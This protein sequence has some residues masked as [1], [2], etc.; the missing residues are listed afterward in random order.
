MPTRNLFLDEKQPAQEMQKKLLRVLQEGPLMNWE[1]RKKDVDIGSI[2]A[3]HV[4]LQQAWTKAI[5]K[6]LFYR[7][8]VFHIMVRLCETE[9]RYPLL[10]QHFL[11]KY[12]SSEKCMG[13]RQSHEANQ[14]L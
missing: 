6:G 3:T 9:R 14:K 12:F 4:D 5:S 8:N 2:A 7:L 1:H 13:R 11:D 10:P